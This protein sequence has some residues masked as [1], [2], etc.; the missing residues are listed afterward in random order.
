MNLEN[1]ELDLLKLIYR[2]TGGRQKKY[3]SVDA[4]S[5]VC[6]LSSDDFNRYLLRLCESG[7]V[8]VKPFKM[9][10]ITHEGILVCEEGEVTPRV[11][12][13]KRV[14]DEIRNLTGGD[15]EVFLNID[16]LAAELNLMRYEL[17]DVLN[18]LEN[19]GYVKIHSR[20]SISLNENES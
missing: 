14:L 12:L 18:Y 10:R 8:E 16:A 6:A 19:E 3:F 2:E 13:R 7:Y 20:I 9:G 15:S 17:F 5:R 11:D 4:L 1:T